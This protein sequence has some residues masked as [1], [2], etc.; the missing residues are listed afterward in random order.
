MNNFLISKINLN[1]KF[2]FF[3]FIYFIVFVLTYINNYF[4]YDYVKIRDYQEI[5]TLGKTVYNKLLKYEK[6]P[7]KSIQE[8]EIYLKILK[9]YSTII[10]K[11]KN[12]ILLQYKNIKPRH[13]NRKKVSIPKYLTKIDNSNLSLI[14]TKKSIP[15]I[16]YST[17][18]SITF[19]VEDLILKINEKGF[20]KTF[21]WYVNQKIYLRSQHVVLYMIFAYFFVKLLKIKQIQYNQK[22]NTQNKHI[23]S[24]VKKFNEMQEN[25]L[26][27]KN[28]IN[29][30]SSANIDIIEK[31]RQY[32]SVINPPIDLSKY[33]DIINLDPESIIFKCRKVTEKIVISLY[34]TNIGNNNFKNLDSMIKE[35]KNK[36]FLN[37]KASSYANTIKAFGNIS[38]HPNFNDPI[39]FTKDDAK[40]ISNA[41]ILFIEELNLK[42]D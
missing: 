40:I 30:L 38:A 39:E 28:I 17:I 9:P 26:E 19:S 18:R 4:F 35:L 36:N 8:I 6:E 25:E 11:D 10:I 24:L 37:K 29:E 14:I 23:V 21:Y 42:K 2:I 20:L 3:L 16:F 33:K 32:H 15:N 5:R 34:L 1:S 13:V 27:L 41:L 12:N 31:M 7:K 22:I